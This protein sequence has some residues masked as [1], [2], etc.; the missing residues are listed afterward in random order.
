M[1]INK[2]N[3]LNKYGNKKNYMPKDNNNPNNNT[4]QDI[5]LNHIPNAEYSRLSV[6]K[7]NTVDL[8]KATRHDINNYIG[9]LIGGAIGDALGWPVEFDSLSDIK[10]KYGQDGITDLE[11][12]NNKAEITDDTQMTIF[13]ADGLLK[14]AI[15]GINKKMLN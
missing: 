13:T 9:C 11:I 7:A 10:Q 2:I 4:N 14:A 1:L 3:L 8:N 6:Q 5:N 12:V 15:K